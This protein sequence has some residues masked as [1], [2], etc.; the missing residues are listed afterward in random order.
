MLRLRNSDGTTTPPPE[1]TSFIELCDLQG[2]VAMAIFTDPEGRIHILKQGDPQFD[3]YLAL[4]PDTIGAE[5]VDPG[6]KI[7]PT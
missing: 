3:T 7:M 4:F 1:G 5:V 6:P 2:S